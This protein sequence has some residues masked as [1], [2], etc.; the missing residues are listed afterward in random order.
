MQGKKEEKG[1][2]E[3]QKLIEIKP[4]NLP[5]FKLEIILKKKKKELA[6]SEPTTFFYNSRSSELGLCG[7]GR[8]VSKSSLFG[9]QCRQS[10]NE[11]NRR[12]RTLAGKKKNVKQPFCLFAFFFSFF[13]FIYFNHAQ[14]G[15]FFLLHVNGAVHKVLVSSLPSPL[16]RSC[17]GSQLEP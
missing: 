2:E 1:E 16:V 8:V 13:L 6:N 15:C 12:C 7:S 3:R 5:I 14:Q 17:R 11:F 4:Q 10:H 9:V